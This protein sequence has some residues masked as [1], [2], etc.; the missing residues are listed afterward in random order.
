MQHT[1]PEP[2]TINIPEEVLHDLRERLGRVRWPGEIPNSDW[3][4]GSN[5]AYMKELVEY[6]RTKYDWRAQERQLNTWP[7]F[8]VTIDG[9]RIHYIHARGKGPKPLPLIITHG[10]PGSIYEFMEVIGPLTDPAAHGGD[11]ADAFDVI[12]PSLPGYGFSDP[13]NRRKVNISQIAEWFA[14]LMKDVLGY[15]RYGAQGGDWGAMVTSRLG[16]ANPQNVVGIHLNMVGV[17][18]H[19][20]NRQNLSPAEQEFLKSMGKWRGEETGY[21]GIQGTKPQTLGYGLNDSPTGLCAWITE[22]F[23]TWSDCDG[24]VE[25]SY[26]KDQLL[27]NITIYWV[28]QTINSST[29]LY[30]EERH[31]PWLMGK[32]EKIAVPTAIALFPKEIACPP[33][34]WAERA[35]NV[36]RWT[37]MPAG[38]HFAAM[39][40]PKLLVDDVRA[41]FRG[42]R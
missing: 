13:T 12:A 24:N 19:P 21:Q 29:R 39:E 3:D 28:T 36:Q 11:P 10:W 9:Q 30:Y 40:Q 20:A 23:R 8:K 18:P 25:K 38:G 5:L 16:F 41:F 31:H 22:K 37:P 42:L 6:W 2:F 14:V 15:A 17:A 26:T 34:E 1:T 33:R 27:T 32:D 7:H 35:Y 4:Y